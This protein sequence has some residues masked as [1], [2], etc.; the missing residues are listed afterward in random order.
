MCN[1]AWLSLPTAPLRLSFSVSGSPV[2]SYSCDFPVSTRNLSYRHVLVIGRQ[3]AG[4]GFLA[5]LPSTIPTISSAEAVLINKS[6][7]GSAF[8]KI[9]WKFYHFFVII[10]Y[11]QKVFPC[12]ERY[13]VDNYSFRSTRDKKCPQTQDEG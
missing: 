9:T 2:T 10:I 8:F 4:R 13:V 12:S 3:A 6:A 1:T 7:C 11:K 5:I